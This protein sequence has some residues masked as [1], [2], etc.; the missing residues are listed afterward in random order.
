MFICPSTAKGVARLAPWVPM[1]SHLDS[2][3]LSVSVIVNRT[4][5]R[6]SSRSAPRQNAA[7]LIIDNCVHPDYRPILRD[8]VARGGNGHSLQSRGPVRGMPS[9]LR[10]DRDMRNVTGTANLHL[11]RSH[12]N[13]VLVSDF[14]GTMTR[15]DF[16]QLARARWWDEGDSDPGQEYLEGRMTP[17]RSSQRFFAVSGATKHHSL[18]VL[19]EWSLTLPCPTPSSGLPTLDGEWLSRRR[20]ASGTSNTCSRMSGAAGTS[21]QPRPLQPGSVFGNDPPVSS[22]VL[23]PANRH[24]QSR[25]GPA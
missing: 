21:C 14:D 24:R 23:Q 6:G 22:P 4:G 12:A 25:G 16:Y 5:R 20:D 2:S 1:V 3:E 7:R 13:S 11:I 9:E 10:Q 17:F 19:M 8:Y 18:L 15:H